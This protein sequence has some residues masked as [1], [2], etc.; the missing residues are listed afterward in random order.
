MHSYWQLWEN[1]LS[2]E[3]CDYIIDKALTLP[4]QDATIGFGDTNRIDTDYRKSKIRWIPRGDF[5]WADVYN[6]V[7]TY[8]YQANNYAFG[9][10][11]NRVLEMQFTEYD[12]ADEGKYDWHEDI[13]WL[14]GSC[15]HRK[16]S[17]VIQL[18][19]P[20]NYTGG[21]LELAPP[22]MSVPDTEILRKKGSVIAFPSFVKHR[23]T[24]VKTGKRYSLVAWM[25]GPKFR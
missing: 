14:N 8:I 10:E 18:S 3:Y 1:G 21:E 24:P 11:L 23:V 25:E 22:E 2:S 19:D 4:V 16:V 13:N 15:S 6:L 20:A 7:E 5:H 17:L 9:F 12:E